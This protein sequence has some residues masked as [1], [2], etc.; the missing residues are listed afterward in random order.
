MFSQNF[1]QC[2]CKQTHQIGF[3]IAHNYSSYRSAKR[4]SSELRQTIRASDGLEE[5]LS[6]YSSIVSGLP[7]S[8]LQPN[9]DQTI[10]NGHRK[11]SFVYLLL[12]PRTTADREREIKVNKINIGLL[13]VG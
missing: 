10:Q 9:E 6:Q 11:T 1:N 4:F 13:S 2:V 5:Q 8:V 3:T 12:D 7:K